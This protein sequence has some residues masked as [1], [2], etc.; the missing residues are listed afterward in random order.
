[1]V[2]GINV[3]P[4]RP[5]IEQLVSVTAAGAAGADAG[6]TDSEQA[7]GSAALDSEERIDDGRWRAAAAAAATLVFACGPGEMI[8]SA[9][10]AAVKHGC[11]FHAESFEL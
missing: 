2:A 6:P 1:M 10:R 11:H 3:A 5:D 9:R 4:G 7:D 8:D